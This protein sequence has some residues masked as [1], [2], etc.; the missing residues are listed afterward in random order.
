MIKLDHAFR[1]TGPWDKLLDS[2][3]SLGQFLTKIEKHCTDETSYISNEDEKKRLENKFRGDAFEV[4]AE[5]LLKSYPSDRRLGIS[6]YQPNTAKDYG[7]DG[8][9]TGTNLNP[10]TVQVK[11]R[12]DPKYELTMDDGL[13]NFMIAS[14]NNP[15]IKDRVLLDDTENMLVITSAKCINYKTKEEMLYEKVRE[16]N[17][18]HLKQFVDNNLPFWEEFREATQPVT[19][20]APTEEIL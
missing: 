18:T 13:G 2:V 15:D 19:P 6:K 4:F 8:F 16:C 17:R 14:Q 20:P 10:A 12:G 5:M 11:Y 9:G 1:Y 3:A 7:I